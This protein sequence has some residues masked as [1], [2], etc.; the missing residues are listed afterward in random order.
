MFEKNDKLAFKKEMKKFHPTILKINKLCYQYKELKDEEFKI[1]SEKL[2]ER[3][4]NGEELDK[5][6]PEAFAL[7]K[8]AS[9]RVLGMAHFTEQLIGGIILHQGRVAEL[10]TG[11]GK[12]LVATL[13]AYLNALTGNPVHI[14]TANDYLAKRDAQFV[15]P[16]FD[17][18][19]MRVGHLTLMQEGDSEEK[20]R[21]YNCDILY[22]IH[23]EFGF[24]Y[25]RDNLVQ[26]RNDKVQRKLN[27]VIIDEI[28]SILIDDAK[29]PL[30]ISGFMEEDSSDIE[31]IYYKVHNFVKKLE[32]QRDFEIELESKLITLTNKGIDKA[33]KYFGFNHF[34]EIE[35][36]EIINIINQSL[37]AN[38]ILCKDKDYIV[39]DN[40]I[41]IIDVATGRV[42]EGREF[43]NH[44]HQM[45]EVKEGLDVS[46]KTCVFATI[47]YQN[48]FSLYEKL[49]G[50][51]GTVYSSREEFEEIYKLDVVRVNT[52]RPIKRIDREDIIYSTYENK[53][54]GILKEIEVAYKKSQPVL[55][56]T[57]SIQETNNLSELLT[58]YNIDHKVLNAKEVDKEA[59]I[60]AKAGKLGAI[61]IATNMAGR[62]TDIKLEDEA[63][64]V[65]GLKV[66][67]TTRNESKRVDDQ[68]RGRAG[69][70]GDV[71]ESVFIIS[72]EDELI[73]DSENKEIEI[74]KKRAHL[75]LN[76]PISE[77]YKDLAKIIDKIQRQTEWKNYEYRKYQL[78]YDNVIN[79]QREV[80]YNQREDIINCDMEKIFE[81]IF[82]IIKEISENLA[83]IC[84]VGEGTSDKDEYIKIIKDNF[85][86]IG[87]EINDDIYDN[88]KNEYVEDYIYNLIKNRFLYFKISCINEVLLFNLKRIVLTEIDKGWIEHINNMELIKMNAIFTIGG[89]SDPVYDYS[90][91]GGKAFGA[92]LFNI[93]KNILKT[94]FSLIQIDDNL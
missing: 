24:D 73:K 48:F 49:S 5:V 22:G 21:C 92:M 31:V 17:F 35:N 19:G 60:I 55:V 91:E 4:K 13:P 53:M 47:T 26:N 10:K 63:L 51:S 16:L 84:S 12:T 90:I 75:Y 88:L 36:H 58:K 2:K 68:L 11:E 62:G 85:L 45:L 7:V 64:Q 27:Y 86:D 33:E 66:I 15:K 41:E 80:I 74:F 65:G 32:M 71:G 54:Y 89:S 8:E 14:I 25:L 50:M 59:E 20:K 34:S 94:I 29:T 69:R 6:L 93:K 3:V 67:G 46:K 77:R 39:K 83:V 82:K 57:S 56:G 76:T 38:F 52:H 87:Y 9:R 30:I 70:Q 44:L 79:L 72:L 40:K 23:S 61:T 42:L 1:K 18:L 37:R 81:V 43:S 28:D 78:K